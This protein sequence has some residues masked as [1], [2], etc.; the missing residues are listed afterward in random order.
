M[1]LFGRK[2][3]NYLEFSKRH[4]VGRIASIISTEY[5]QNLGAPIRYKI[6]AGRTVTPPEG[7]D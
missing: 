2:A 1:S 6:D 4:P 5:H 7:V 3:M